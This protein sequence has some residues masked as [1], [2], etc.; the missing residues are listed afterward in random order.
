MP[1]FVTDCPRCGSQHMTM[2]V[3]SAVYRYAQY[4]WQRWYEVFC[5]CRACHKPS[6]ILAAQTEVKAPSAITTETVLAYR[7]SL[8]D[9]LRPEGPI[10][11]KDNFAHS[12]PDFLPDDVLRI[13]SEAV[14]CLA[15]N[16]YNA[17]AT[18]F[19]LCLDL[20]TR[21]M[22]PELDNTSIPQPNSKQRRDLGLRLQW[23]FE[24]GAIPRELE[25]LSGC[26]REDGN[27]AA[28]RG[29]LSKADAE[30]LL[31]FTDALLTRLITEP[32]KLRLAAKRRT[33]RR[34]PN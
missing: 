2:D 12:P 30:D 21:P 5:V 8:N 18:M 29:T 22:L 27:D 7:G 26:V 24:N 9:F 17:S 13:Y 25:H 4:N 1:I 20:A 14:N 28:H 34:N 31:D 19:R 6:I 3:S 11:L 33:E 16:C 32:E 23:M 15:I 10:T